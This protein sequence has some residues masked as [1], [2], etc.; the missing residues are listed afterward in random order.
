[1]SDT[2]V[3]PIYLNQVLKSAEVAS[4]SVVN[5]PNLDLQIAKSLKHSDFSHPWKDIDPETHVKKI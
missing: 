1:M 3:A 5:W 2:P 4:R